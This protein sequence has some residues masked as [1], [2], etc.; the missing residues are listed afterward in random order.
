MFLISITKLNCM[1]IK[2]SG[3]IFRWFASRIWI[4]CFRSLDPQISK[5]VFVYAYLEQLPKSSQKGRK[6]ASNIYSII[7]DNYFLFRLL[8][9]F[10]KEFNVTVFSS[11]VNYQSR[12]KGV[13][14]I[15]NCE[16]RVVADGWSNF[17]FLLSF[18]L[19]FSF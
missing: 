4:N 18:I 6:K 10:Y 14:S 17:L 13:K 19:M 16:P 11:N 1:Q 9:F 7:K 15:D 8:F 12:K 3:I 2:S 5:R